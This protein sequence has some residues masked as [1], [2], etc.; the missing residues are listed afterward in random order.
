MREGTLFEF[1]S[2]EEALAAAVALRAMGFAHL[3][4]YTPYPVPELDAALALRRTRIPRAVFAAAAFGCALAFAILWATNAYD[5]PL[6]V[7]GRPLNSLPA[8]IPIMFETTVLLGSLAAFALVFV[9]S[10]LPRLHRPIFAVEGIQ[11]VSV[12]RFWIGIEQARPV[13]DNVCARM[14]GMGALSICTLQAGPS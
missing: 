7:G 2:A 6:D 14:V 5:Y 9:R 3:D 1:A 11:S 10:G 8:D 13:D 12:D 4:A